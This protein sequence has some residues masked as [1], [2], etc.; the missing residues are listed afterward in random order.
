M[1]DHPIV[2]FEIPATDTKATGKFYGD[3]FGWKIETS[4]EFDYVMFQSEGGPG[5]GFVGISAPAHVEYK[6]DRLLVYL[7]TEDIE[8][9]L[10]TIEAHGG[11]TVLAKT[12]IPGIGWWAVF[13]D[14][15]GNHLGLF[16]SVPR[17]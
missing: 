13:T 11:K 7:G 5:G 17:S 16:T 15:N 14:P 1:A 10:A 9:T 12:E 3:V 8:A 6:L 2:H 4:P